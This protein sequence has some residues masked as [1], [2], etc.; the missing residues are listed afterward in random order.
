MRLM[1]EAN[2]IGVFVGIESPDPSTLIAMRKKQNTRRDIAQ[3]VHRIY[4]AGLY[5]TAGFILGFD[6][7][8]GSVADAIV[9]LIEEAAIPVCMVGLLYALP[10]TQLTRRLASEGRLHRIFCWDPAAGMDQCT[11]GLNFDTLRPRQEILSDYKHVLERSLRT[12]CLCQTA[13]TFGIVCSEN[14]TRIVKCVRTIHGADLADWRSSI[15]LC[16]DCR[17]HRI[18]SGERSFNVHRQIHNGH[19]LSSC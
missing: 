10:N 4:A 12:R 14:Q 7:E 16:P 18:F 5:V 1:N 11:Q 3:S 15:G 17:G 9:E 19:G 13:S 8:Q 6:S 2:F